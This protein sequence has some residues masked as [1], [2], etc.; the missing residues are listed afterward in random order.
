M[1]AIAM[2]KTHSTGFDKINVNIAYT[3]HNI[4]K[5]RCVQ[6]SVF[7]FLHIT[8]NFYFSPTLRTH[9]SLK[10]IHKITGESLF[11]R[12]AAIIDLFPSRSF[13]TCVSRTL[14][15]CKPGDCN[16]CT[17]QRLLCHTYTYEGIVEKTVYVLAP[18]KKQTGHGILNGYARLF[19]R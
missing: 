2:R 7:F 15:A 9:R 10:S 6:Y 13:T 8:Y 16:T 11:N 1:T 12:F 14:S 18:A 19:R 4:T 5:I 17:P 3:S